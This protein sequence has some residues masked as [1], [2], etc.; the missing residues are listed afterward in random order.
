VVDKDGEGEE[1]P[2]HYPPELR[3]PELDDY[4]V[5]ILNWFGQ[6]CTG[7]VKEY[8]LM[9]HLL[10]ELELSYE[11]KDFLLMKLSV[12]YGTLQKIEQERIEEMKNA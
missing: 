12:I 8:G 9:P 7:F 11:D 3:R 6:N 5:F 2:E 10:A 4:D 1:L